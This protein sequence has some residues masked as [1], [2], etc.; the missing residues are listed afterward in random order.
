[1]TGN[2]FVVGCHLTD[3]S[4]YS[5]DSQYAAT[6]NLFGIFSFNRWRD[7]TSGNTNGY[8]DWATA[9]NWGN[10]TTDTGG[11]ETDFVDAANGNFLLINSA[12]GA[13][14]GVPPYRDIGALQRAVTAGAPR[15]GDRTG[16]LR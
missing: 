15:F 4:G 13:G 12:P 3:A 1:V 8:A 5:I 14:T 11:V 2:L 10:V 9:T 16:G 7:N 6:A